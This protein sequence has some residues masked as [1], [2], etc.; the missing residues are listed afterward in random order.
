MRWNPFSWSIE[1]HHCE[2]E[3]MQIMSSSIF[4]NLP[5]DWGQT[6]PPA[7]RSTNEHDDFNWMSHSSAAVG[8]FWWI[9]NLCTLRLCRPGS[10]SSLSYNQ[11]DFLLRCLQ[12]DSDWIW[13]GGEAARRI[14]QTDVYICRDIW[15]Q[16][17]Y[18][19]DQTSW[20]KR[21]GVA[22]LHFCSIRK[23]YILFSICQESLHSFQK[24]RRGPGV[25]A[26]EQ[27]DEWRLC[28]L[29]LCSR[30]TVTQEATELYTK[31]CICPCVTH[32]G[33]KYP[34]ASTLKI[35][36]A[37]PSHW[38]ICVNH[39]FLLKWQLELDFTWKKYLSEWL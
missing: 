20:R 4:I 2:E 30:A 5:S 34:P 21:P 33:F 18:Q 19:L 15:S 9:P 16:C 22:C 25:S 31:H 3:S 8:H 35:I 13:T 17:W 6:K 7:R 14:P 27:P 37:P 29:L 38:E 28:C 24:Q 1:F 11:T 26:H 36:E 12:S 23:H 39:G 32:W 10:C